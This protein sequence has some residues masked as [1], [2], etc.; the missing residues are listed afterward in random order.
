MNLLSL[1]I[2]I[3][4]FSSNPLLLNQIHT[5][6]S[7]CVQKKK[8]SAK[9]TEEKKTLWTLKNES[10]EFSNILI[11]IELGIKWN[12]MD[13]IKHRFWPESQFSISHCND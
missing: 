3:A 5:Q 12:S 7:N 6:Y 4:S 2:C 10:I 1:A 13:L 9:N 11:T 8:Y